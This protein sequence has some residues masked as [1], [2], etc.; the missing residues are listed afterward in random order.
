VI[1]LAVLFGPGRDTSATLDV[2]IATG[3]RGLPHA[4][5]TLGRADAPV[6]IELFE[7]FQCPACKRWGES[8]LP[9]LAANEL[10]T[11]S[12][13]IVFRDFAFLGP[14]SFEAARAGFAA[15]QQDR[16]W[17]FW[18]TVYANQ[19]L[20][21]SGALSRDRL[22]AMAA[23]LGLDEERFTTDL[24]SVAAGDA[25]AAANRVAA[26]AGIN[27]TPT[28]VIDGTPLVAATYPEIRAAIEAAQ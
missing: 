21:N 22:L 1:V 13:R 20:E 8:V 23:G 24:D 27:S 3:P 16:F 26:Q 25:V 28:V 7:D 6:T 12:A 19:G 14:E 15:A 11:G 10:A 4:G 9:E 18:A 5:Y 2:A 17:Q